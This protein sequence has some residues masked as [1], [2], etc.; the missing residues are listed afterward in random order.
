MAEHRQTNPN[1]VWLCMATHG[2]HDDH[3][4][5]Q[6]TRMGD[7]LT[8]LRFDAMSHQTYTVDVIVC[9]TLQTKPNQTKQ[10][11]MF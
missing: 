4:N 8:L 10:V 9:H 1:D 2:K 11:V 7:F 6:E 3:P 5:E